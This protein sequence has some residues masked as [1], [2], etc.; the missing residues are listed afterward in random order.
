MITFNEDLLAD[1]LAYIV[2]NDLL[3]HAV[4]T[5][6]SEKNSA[7]VVNN[8]K[9]DNVILS[10]TNGVESRVHLKSGESYNA[11]LLVRYF[12]IIIIINYFHFG[13]S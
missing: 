13:K 11:K 5:C 8:A 1:D 7:T 2:E 10:N 9:I 12:I 3:L 6:L 4:N